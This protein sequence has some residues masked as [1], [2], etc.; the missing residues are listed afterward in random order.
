MA[1]ARELIAQGQFAKGSMLPK[2]QA[3]L[4]FLEAGGKEALITDPEHL[5]EALAG[6]TG[7]HLVR[8]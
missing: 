4:N 1:E 7:T 5:M 2:I 3:C 8:E 6:K